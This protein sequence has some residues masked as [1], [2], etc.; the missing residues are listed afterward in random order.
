MFRQ[1]NNLLH[2]FAVVNLIFQKIHSSGVF[3]WEGEKKEFLFSRGKIGNGKMVINILARSVH[4]NS[5]TRWFQII[6]GVEYWFGSALKTTILKFVP[7]WYAPGWQADMWHLLQIPYSPKNVPYQL[8][9]PHSWGNNAC[10]L[11]TRFYTS[12]LVIA[13]ICSLSLTLSTWFVFSLYTFAHVHI[14]AVLISL[15]V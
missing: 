15:F 11:Q 5:S 10:F 13:F 6:L 2:M 4:F 3:M 1:L 7:A 8:S 9:R 14:N 12:L